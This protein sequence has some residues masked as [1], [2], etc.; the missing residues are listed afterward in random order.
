LPMFIEHAC[1]H[2]PDSYIRYSELFTVYTKFLNQNKRRTV[3]KKEFS[4]RLTS[5][6]FE[7]RRTSKEGQIDQYVEG[8]RWKNKVTDFGGFRGFRGCQENGTPNTCVNMKYGFSDN[9]ENPEKVLPE[10]IINKENEEN[11]E[12]KQIIHQPCTICGAKISHIFNKQGKPL[13]EDCFKGLEA[14]KGLKQA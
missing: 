13:C 7:N 5:E 2:E 11:I 4:I 8:I 14:Q 10:G 1:I 6:G 12:D 3:S 9:P